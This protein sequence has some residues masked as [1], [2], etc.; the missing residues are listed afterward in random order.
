MIRYDDKSDVGTMTKLLE[1]LILEDKVD[2]VLPPWSTGMLY[3][4]APICQKHAYILIGGPGGAE[5]L[6]ELKLPYFFQVL[7]FAETQMPALA[8]IFAEVGVKSAA[9]ISRGDLHGIEYSERSVPEM[10][11][12]GIEVKMKESYPPTT[13]DLSSL[14]KQAKS[15]DVDAFVVHGYP[16]ETMLGTSQA[17]EL[18]INFKALRF[19]VGPCFT[20]YRDA[21]GVKA[22]EGVI[23]CGA[24]NAKTS[25]GAAELCE[26]YKEVMGHEMT[27]YWGGLYYYSSLQH[28][29]QAIEEAG[30]LGQSKIRELI[31]F[32]LSGRNTDNPI[33]LSLHVDLGADTG[34][35]HSLPPKRPGVGGRRVEEQGTGR[36]ACPYLKDKG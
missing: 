16:D 2:F 3:A 8:E 25:P 32:R 17:M 1:K 5:K 31:V 14:L 23:G 26:H 20:F 27:D 35:G 4:A 34:P 15:L 19:N 30:T 11:K 6:K 12:R 28:F 21:F 7:N 36:A 22:V 9:V 10:E 29:R 13:K 18:G 33:P 24:W